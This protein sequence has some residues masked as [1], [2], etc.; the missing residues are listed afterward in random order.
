LNP[1]GKEVRTMKIVEL[2]AAD[3]K[4]VVGGARK[5]TKKK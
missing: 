1:Y 2:T 3:L 5:K 4:R